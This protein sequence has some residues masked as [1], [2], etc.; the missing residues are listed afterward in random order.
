MT[1]AVLDVVGVSA[2]TVIADRLNPTAK[3]QIHGLLFLAIIYFLILN[4]INFYSLITTIQKSNNYAFMI[5][6]YLYEILRRIFNT[7]R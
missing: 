7:G 3:S 5:T 1:G 4:I 2:N 6:I